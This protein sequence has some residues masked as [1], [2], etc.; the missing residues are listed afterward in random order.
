MSSEL[1]VGVAYAGIHTPKCQENLS[2]F[3]RFKIASSLDCFDYI[4]ATPDLVDVGEMLDCSKEFGLPVLAGSCNY[5]MGRD[6]QK[7]KQNLRIASELGSMRHNTQLF[8]DHQ[9]G[10]LLSNQEVVKFY[11]MAYEWGEMYACMPCFEVHVN[12]W[13]EGFHRIH[14]VADLV[15]R[16]GVPFS[17]TL[18]HSHVVFKAGDNQVEQKVFGVDEKIAR[19]EINIDPLATDNLMHQWIDRGLVAH[20]HARAV[21]IN[22]PKNIWASHPGLDTF[23]SS[24]H[25]PYL[26][27]RGI[28]YPFIEPDVGQWHSQWRDEDLL[29]WKSVMG[30]LLDWHEQ[31]QCTS[32]LALI[33]CEYIPF[34]D[35]GAGAGYSLI[36]NNAACADWLREQIA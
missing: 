21:A 4:E 29:G 10:H 13:S 22:N 1:L 11:L 32:E 16:E 20:A 35:Y 25:P 8:M 9:D 7:L 15:E 27:G 33:T 24:Q 12:M 18:D 3:D 17:M 31:H 23:L 6:E 14:E 34:T 5:K 30:Y 36:E 28:Q 2:I 26:Q 19:G